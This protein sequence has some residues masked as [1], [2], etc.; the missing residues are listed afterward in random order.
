M[1]GYSEESGVA[2]IRIDRPDARNALTAAMRHD[3]VDAFAAAQAARGVRSV[4]LTGSGGHFCAGGDIAE[5]GGAPADGL[6]RVRRSHALIR[7]ISSIDK[8]VVAAV[9]GSCIGIGWSLALAC[10]LVIAAAD[11]RF[12]FGFQ[13]LGLAPDGAAS[14]LLVR[15]VGL[16]RA[17]ELIYTGRFVSGSEAAALGLALEAIDTDR[18]DARALEFAASLASAPTLAV[19]MAKRQLDLASGQ[20]LEAALALEAAMQP[21]MQQTADFAEGVAA[22]REK[23]AARFTGE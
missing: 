14:M 13:A 4:I 19:G 17:K 6:I 23:R 20:T 8:P 16:M 3:L 22:M 10:D 1:I 7:A 18:V 5:M 15:Q 12:R 9:R 11:A 2:T 21:L